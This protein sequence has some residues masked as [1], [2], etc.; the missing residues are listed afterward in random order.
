MNRDPWPLNNMVWKLRW[1]IVGCVSALILSAYAQTSTTTTAPVAE[2]QTTHTS[3]RFRER[4][5]D[6]ANDEGERGK[7]T[8]SDH[9]GNRYSER[10]HYNP[11]EFRRLMKAEL[12]QIPS[13]KPRM[14]RLMDIQAQRYELQK[15]RRAVAS[16][17]GPNR[18]AT[19]KKFH[20]LLRK[21]ME[22]T[23]ESRRIMK[24][25]SQDSKAIQ[26]DMDKRRGELN[27]LLAEENTKPENSETSSKAA[28]DYRRSLRYVDFIDRKLSDLNTRPERFDL[29]SRMLRGLPIE[30]PGEMGPPP[31]SQTLDELQDRRKHLQ[32]QLREVEEAIARKKGAPQDSS[33]SSPQ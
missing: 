15:Q 16:Q 8:N 28:Q 1:A 33:T 18:D 9:D 19:I 20:E 11:E 5:K 3:K 25:M 2:Q 21:D 4:W 23:D 10:H 30:D 14:D 7:D 26:Q 29:L 27:R 24:Q 13:L 12:D 32:R 31:K 22:L 6:R 17:E